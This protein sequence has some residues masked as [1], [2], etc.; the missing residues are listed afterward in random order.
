MILKV[1][2]IKKDFKKKSVLSDI[3]FELNEGEIVGLV[4]QNGAG[5]STLMKIVTGL[6]QSS[7][8]SV[9]I[10][11][12]A[13]KEDPEIYLSQIGVLL[14]TASFDPNMTGFSA[15]IYLAKL[16][17]TSCGEVK[18]LLEKVGLEVSS[19]LRI[20]QFSLG[21]KQRLGVAQAL[22]VHPKILILD[23]PFNGLDLNGVRELRDLLTHL[24]KEGV[25]TL[26]SSHDL[27]ELD[28]I[29]D[30]VLFLADK[31]IVR[32]HQL[33]DKRKQVYI[34]LN[35]TDNHRAFMIIRKKDPVLT[36]VLQDEFLMIEKTSAGDLARLIV[37]LENNDLKVLEYKEIIP[38]LE[39]T[40][41][42][43]ILGGTKS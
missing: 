13:Y 20:K 9:T 2:R 14:D 12:I 32:E 5:K 30:R 8:G 1:E 33:G 25:T 43:V 16:R 4:G 38:H 3:S 17:G 22:L 19:K 34:A 28:L 27:S 10:N 23:E 36:P 18:N 37:N 26:L 39:D 42:E 21:M 6:I 24:R 35:T 29:C 11:D 31:T 41:D 15:L 7:A 40:Y